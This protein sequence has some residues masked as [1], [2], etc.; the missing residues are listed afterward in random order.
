MCK[1]ACKGICK[2]KR[3]ECKSK[4]EE[5]D[6]KDFEILEREDYQKSEDLKDDE[7]DLESDELYHN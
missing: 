5:K 1:A 4:K 6:L 3:E 2:S 7:I